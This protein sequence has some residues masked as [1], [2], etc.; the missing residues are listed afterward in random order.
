MNS[1]EINKETLLGTRKVIPV[2]IEELGTVYIKSFP[3]SVAFGDNTDL[4]QSGQAYVASLVD[5]KGMRLFQDDEVQGALENIDHRVL[6][7]II[8]AVNK[9]NNLGQQADDAEKN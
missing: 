8:E 2:E 4:F 5:G 7:Q 1:K 6:K 9:A 3:A